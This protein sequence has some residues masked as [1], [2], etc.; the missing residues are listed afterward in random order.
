[1]QSV[2]SID[3]TGENV[4]AVVLAVDGRSVSIIERRTLPSGGLF[5]RSHLDQLIAATNSTAATSTT[6]E[7]TSTT[8]ARPTTTPFFQ[9]LLESL[10]SPWQRAVLIV[11]PI[12]SLALNVDLPFQDPKSVNKIIDLEVQDI[13]PFGIEE[14]V[15]QYKIIGPGVD[16]GFDAHVSIFPKRY[17]RAILDLC[18]QGNL[19]PAVVTTPASCLGAAYTLAP[20]YLAPNSAILL[21]RGS[22]HYLLLAIGGLCRTERVLNQQIVHADGNR[23]ENGVKQLLSELKLT[24]ASAERRYKKNIEKIYLLG[25]SLQPSEVQQT[26][27]RNTERLSIG[28]LIPACDETATLAGLGGVFGQ[29]GIA[30]GGLTNFRTREFSYSPQMRELVAAARSLIPYAITT[31]AAALICLTI[32]FVLRENRISHVSDAIIA[33][34]QSEFP[35]IKAERGRELTNL[36]AAKNGLANQLKDL[37]TPSSITPLDALLEIALILDKVKDV[38]LTRV[39]IRGNKANIEATV[40]DYK[41]I[42]Q[43]ETLFKRASDKRD[44][45]AF[46]EVRDNGSN[47]PRASFELTLC[48]Q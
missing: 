1:M 44:C 13:V 9:T 15:V 11:P 34:I 38:E 28:E 23:D 26:L 10:R 45:K 31:V 17:L 30:N 33:E 18:H 46:Y 25:S 48:G 42:D 27:G 36:T 43:L 24:T 3:I 4:E 8:L 37:G 20:D 32:F 35:Q 6:T 47:A 41:T 14:F 12:D 7:A 40:K 16:H 2:L 19:E 5:G 21:S 39:S 29:D 22:N